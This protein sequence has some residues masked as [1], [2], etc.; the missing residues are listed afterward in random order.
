MWHWILL[1]LFVRKLLH[2]TPSMQIT[3][4]ANLKDLFP[5]CSQRISRRLVRYNYQLRHTHTQPELSP[6][7][8]GFRAGVDCTVPDAAFKAN[9][10]RTEQFLLASYDIRNP[11]L[12]WITPYFLAATCDGSTY[13]PNPS[14][15]AGYDT[16]SV[17]KRSLTG[18]EFRVFL[19]LD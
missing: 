13:L 6:G 7:L 11:K 19:L 17:F 5:V 15:R 1:N 9:A 2:T 12:T 16:R 4:F 8:K 3:K 10:E 14:A 18:F